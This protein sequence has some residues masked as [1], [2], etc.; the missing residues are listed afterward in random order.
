MTRPA[1]RAA[2]YLVDAV[3]PTPHEWEYAHGADAGTLWTR[4]DPNRRRSGAQAR[5]K[6]S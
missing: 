3:L 5:D 6:G 1:H 4:G 2:G